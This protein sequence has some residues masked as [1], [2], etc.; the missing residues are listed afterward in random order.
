V[1]HQFWNVSSVITWTNESA[2]AD[3][4]RCSCCQNVLQASLT[5]KVHY[6]P[7][8]HLFLREGEIFYTLTL[9]QG[10]EK[11][12][13][14]NHG[15][16]IEK[17]REKNICVTSSFCVH[18]GSTTNRSG[19]LLDKKMCMCKLL[20][21][22]LLCTRF[23]RSKMNEKKIFSSGCWSLFFRLVLATFHTLSSAGMNERTK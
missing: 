2:A 11:Q 14:K 23:F 18:S 17:E 22:L 13:N 9:G 7:T 21:S 4:S 3:F 12:N 10:K 8:Y 20:L 16:Y 5:L 6:I 1:H 19:H 15:W